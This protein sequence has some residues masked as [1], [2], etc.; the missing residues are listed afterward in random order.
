[1]VDSAVDAHDRG[2]HVDFASSTVGCRPASTVEGVLD[3]VVAC[4]TYL[5]S[6]LIFVREMVPNFN[7]L[8]V[9]IVK[10]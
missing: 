5:L 6:I 3:D 4:P 2:M 8:N 10:D 1:V 9:V 7:G